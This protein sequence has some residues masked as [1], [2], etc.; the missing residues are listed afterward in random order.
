[1]LFWKEVILKAWANFDWT[2]FFLSVVYLIY[3][4]I[5]LHKRPNQDSWLCTVV[6]SF[7]GSWMCAEAKGGDGVSTGSKWDGSYQRLRLLSEVSEA[8]DDVRML[9]VT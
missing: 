5:N 3:S 7:V 1:M 2:F 4:G 6:P 8:S 9:S